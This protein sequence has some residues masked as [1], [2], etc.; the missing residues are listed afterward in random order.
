MSHKRYPTS[1]HDTSL[2]KWKPEQTHPIHFVKY[3]KYNK[4]ILSLYFL[5]FSITFFVVVIFVLFIIVIE[6]TAQKFPFSPTSPLYYKLFTILKCKS[7][8]F[9][10]IKV[11]LLC[12][13]ELHWEKNKTLNMTYQTHTHP[14]YRCS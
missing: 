3:K 13:F 14:C 2:F 9:V 11:L 6:E 12:I 5:K 1:L 8:F 4:R 10:I 7:I